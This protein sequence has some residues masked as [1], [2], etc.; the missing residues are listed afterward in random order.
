MT[1]YYDQWSAYYGEYL[2]YYYQCAAQTN[3]GM[4]PFLGFVVLI[5]VVFIV[6]IIVSALSSSETKE[7]SK[8]PE[9]LDQEAAQLL[10]LKR[11]NDARLQA[12]LSAAELE[13]ARRFITEQVKK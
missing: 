4:P 7:E 11:N 9:Q 1:C 6:L 8:T 12:E 5:G 13:A 10:A 2:R 3:A